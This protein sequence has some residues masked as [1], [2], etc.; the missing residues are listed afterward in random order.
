[1]PQYYFDLV[2]HVT[3]EDNGGQILTDDTA[4]E[5]VADELARKLFEM[6]PELRNKG[7]SMRVK[8][9]EGAEVHRSPLEVLCIRPPLSPS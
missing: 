6:R 5:R 2:D 9:S 4:A 8:D 1:M 3:I 7:Y